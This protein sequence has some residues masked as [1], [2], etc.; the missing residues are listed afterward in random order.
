MSRKFHIGA[1]LVSGSVTST[2]KL[3][4]EFGNALRSQS[5]EIPGTKGTLVGL[6]GGLGTGKTTFVQGIAKAFGI[7]KR[8]VSP[9]FIIMRSYNLE[10]DSS[11][12]INISKLYHVDLYRVPDHNI[13]RE[14]ETVG[15]FDVLRDH[16]NLVF[17]EWADKLTHLQRGTIVIRFQYINSKTRKLF[18]DKIA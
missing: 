1:Q 13:K 17:L 2:K 18:L 4:E 8:V 6:M 7:K 9:T 15:F 14:L 12:K 3:G 16:R 11:S 5:L 10:T